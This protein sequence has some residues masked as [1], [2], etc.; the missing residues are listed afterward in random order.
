MSRFDNRLKAKSGENYYDLR[1]DGSTHSIQVIDYAHH[2]VHAGSS[3][4]LV[5]S[6][7]DLGSIA[8]PQ[9]TCQITFTT[10]ASPE[11][12]IIV[13][14]KS[15]GEALFTILEGFTGGGVGGDAAVALNKHRSKQATRLTSLTGIA[16][17]ATKATGGTIYHNEYI[18][19]G[20]TAS[21]GESRGTQEIILLPSTKYAFQLYDTTGITASIV[22]DWYEHTART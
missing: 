10:P 20:G 9:D 21:A 7:S 5:F 13:H 11:I 15:G 17:Q 18:G 22:L 8:D 3:F 16:T 1:M 14:A 19:Q 12:H 4:H 6:V 2:E